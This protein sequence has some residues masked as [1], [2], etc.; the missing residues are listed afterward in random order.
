MEDA[1]PI[2]ILDDYE[3]R[4]R[5]DVEYLFAFF[6]QVFDESHNLFGDG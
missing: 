6:F 3:E 5:Q 2:Q 1:G 4:H